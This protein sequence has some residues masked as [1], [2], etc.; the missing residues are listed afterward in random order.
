[1]HKKFLALLI[2]GTIMISSIPT[3]YARENA[4]IVSVTED[5]SDAAITAAKEKAKTLIKN[6]EEKITPYESKMPLKQKALINKA[7]SALEKAVGKLDKIPDT[8]T[9]KE[10][11]KKTKAVTTAIETLEKLINTAEEMLEETTEEETIETPTK[12][13]TTKKTITKKTTTKTT[14]QNL[15]ATKNTIKVTDYANKNVDKYQIQ[16]ATN[17]DFKSAKSY[18]TDKS[19]YT[20]KNLKSKTKYYVRI[21]TVKKKGK[22]TTYGVWMATGS[23]KTK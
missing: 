2:A 4:P 16:I 20:I 14:T 1:M 15:T 13:T 12:K 11:A 18:T 17:K 8:A 22:K 3:T 6:L 23:I 21:R 5:Q 9:L 7:K 19:S 10:K